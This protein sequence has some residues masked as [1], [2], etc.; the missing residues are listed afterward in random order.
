MYIYTYIHTS[1]STSTSTSTCLFY[2]HLDMGVETLKLFFVRH[3]IM[4]TD[5]GCF[6]T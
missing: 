5:R 3:E 6:P 2:V 4:R 1:T